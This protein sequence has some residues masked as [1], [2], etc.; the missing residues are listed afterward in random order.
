MVNA[1]EIKGWLET[2]NK[3]GVIEMLVTSQEKII[4]TPKTPFELIDGNK[5]TV[6][7]RK[8]FKT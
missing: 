8:T 3:E 5:L 2:V 4:A 1:E 6:E 7:E